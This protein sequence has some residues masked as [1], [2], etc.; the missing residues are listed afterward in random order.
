MNKRVTEIYNHLIDM[1]KADY[2]YLDVTYNDLRLLVDIN[3]KILGADD[4]IVKKM[5]VHLF[6]SENQNFKPHV[7]VTKIEMDIIRNNIGLLLGLSDIKL[8]KKSLITKKER[9][10]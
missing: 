5:Q 7:P 9:R 6:E 4:F 3:S 2:P 10:K 1:E 8:R